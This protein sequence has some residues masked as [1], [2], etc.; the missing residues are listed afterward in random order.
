MEQTTAA[1]MTFTVHRPDWY[2]GQGNKNS[3]LRRE[4]GTMCCL[5]FYCLAT[6]VAEEDLKDVP[7]P[8]HIDHNASNDSLCWLQ[9][10]EETTGSV[11]E[12]DDYEHII[13]GINDATEQTEEW[14]EAQL[15]AQ[16]A[17]HGITVIFTDER[18]A[19]SA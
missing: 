14:R 3:R 1:P 7:F 10:Q 19:A 2:R 8:S 6:G 17:K 5:G 11:F 18:P 16:F 12:G 13:G 9:E 15:T 4:D